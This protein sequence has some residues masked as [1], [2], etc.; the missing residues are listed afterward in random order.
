MSD[1]DLEKPATVDLTGSASIADM[2]Q[3]EKWDPDRYSVALSEN[4]RNSGMSLDMQRERLTSLAQVGAGLAGDQATAVEIARHWLTLD[5][6]YQ[7]FS[8][9]A[10]EAMGSDRP[11]ASEIADRYLNAALKAQRAAMACLSALKVLREGHR[12][13]DNVTASA[14]PCPSDNA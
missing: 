1:I 2:A 12:P 8:R 11:R 3:A 10:V 7:R 5:A 14:S 13:P 4:I 9:A 6:L